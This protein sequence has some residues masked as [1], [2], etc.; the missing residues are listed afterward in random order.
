LTPEAFSGGRR[1]S[2]NSR[3][4]RD[5]GAGRPRSR[6]SRACVDTG[7]HRPG[8]YPRQSSQKGPRGPLEILGRQAP[9]DRL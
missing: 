4:T 3:N 9:P 6:Q 1:R 2:P 7:S 8:A 5:R